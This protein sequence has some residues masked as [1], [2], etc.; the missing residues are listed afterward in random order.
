MKFKIL[1]VLLFLGLSACAQIPSKEETEKSTEQEEPSQLNLP[2]QALTAPILFDFLLGEVSLQRGKLDIAISRYLKLAKSTRDPRLAKRATEIALH[3][4]HPTAAEQAVSLWVELDPDSVEARQTIAAL[5]VNLGKLDMARPH[6]E[7]LLASEKDGIGN[8]FMQLN[9]LLSRNP[10]KE[11]T[12][13]L[14]QQLAKPYAALPEVHFATS[15]AAWFAQQHELALE[16]MKKAL[17]LRPDWE[18]AAVHNG[19]MLQRVSNIEAAGFYRDYLDS[20]A[21]ANDVRIAYAR[22][23]MAENKVDPAREQLQQLL[24]RNSDNAEVFIAVGLLSGELRDF[25]ITES[26]FKKA[27]SLGYKDPNTIHFHLAALYEETDRPDMAMESYQQ[28]KSG[29]RYLPAQ[30]RYADLLAQKG[31]LNDARQHI[32]KLPAANDQQAA[33]LILA[34]A[35]ILR[36]SGAHQEVFDLLNEGLQKLP[37]YPELLYDRALAADKIG[38][39]EIL[40][41]D[42]RK[43]IKLRPDNAHAYNALGYSL[44]ERGNQLPEALKLIKRAVELSP[45]DPYIMDSLGWVYYRMGNFADGL[46]YLNLAYATRPDPEIAAHLGEVLWVKGAKEDARNIWQSA[47]EKSP[48]N[49]TLRDTMQRFLHQGTAE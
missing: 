12:L 8:A 32:Q 28:V 36:R 39:F 33:H 31:Y 24:A 2:K 27:L 42:L 14:I 41:G 19:R 9:Q 34:E 3:A 48:D 16:E 40:E 23:L 15:Q 25:D 37:D 18:L 44:A 7:K 49:E 38:K 17:A 21:G 43:L 4:G 35:Q 10:N 22:I 30:I 29:G 5:L 45:E 26:T 13:L 11:E 46:N 20:Y 6:L 47:L 1:C